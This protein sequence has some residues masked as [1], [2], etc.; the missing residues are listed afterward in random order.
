MFHF[1]NHSFL[2]T[3][4]TDQKDHMSSQFNENWYTVF[5]CIFS[6]HFIV[7]LR[8][9]SI[10]WVIFSCRVH[11]SRFSTLLSVLIQFLWLTSFLFWIFWIKFSAINLCQRYSLYSQFITSQYWQY[12]VFLFMWYFRTFQNFH[13]IVQSSRTIYQWNCFSISVKIIYLDL[14]TCSFVKWFLYSGNQSRQS[15]YCFHQVCIVLT[16]TLEWHD[17][18]YEALEYIVSFSSLH[19]YEDAFTISPWTVLILI[20]DSLFDLFSF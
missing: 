13:K 5:D 19:I 4:H 10:E 20:I 2:S 6:S 11:H 18:N 1:R 8:L 15:W 9:F 3:S 14:F 12:Q 17:R 16:S 7:T